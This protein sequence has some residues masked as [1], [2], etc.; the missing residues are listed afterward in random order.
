MVV[1]VTCKNEEDTIKNGGA[2]VFATSFIDFSD[3]QRQLT[4]Y[5]NVESGLIPNSSKLLCM[6]LLPTRIKKIQT[7]KAL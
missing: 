3:A 4:P 6:F 1:L 5:L 2:S 7:N